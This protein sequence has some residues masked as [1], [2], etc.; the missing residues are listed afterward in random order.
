MNDISSLSKIMSLFDF[1]TGIYWQPVGFPMTVTCFSWLKVSEINILENSEKKIRNTNCCRMNSDTFRPSGRL[2]GMSEP[3]PTLARIF[4]HTHTQT[5]SE[6]CTPMLSYNDF[7]SCI[8]YKVTHLNLERNKVDLEIQI[9]MLNL[10]H[11]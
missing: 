11:W 7:F 10:L 3:C 4:T 1:D 6:F 2:P 8:K 9:N 5:S